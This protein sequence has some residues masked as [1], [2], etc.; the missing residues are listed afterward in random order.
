MR[1]I[2]YFNLL[3]V[4][5]LSLSLKSM[6][7]DKATEGVI[8]IKCSTKKDKN[9]VEEIFS[10]NLVL[11]NHDKIIL[12]TISNSDSIIRVTPSSGT[13]KD[14]TINSFG[15]SY[16]IVMRNE[17]IV[18]GEIKE[19]SVSWS[20]LSDKSRLTIE[21]LEKKI[22]LSNDL[23]EKKLIAVR[24]KKGMYKISHIE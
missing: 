9:L 6:A 1:H 2:S 21:W 23:I 3:M 13:L 12:I 24:L 22:I 10:R 15:V 7:Q 19:N 18:V 4:L 14:I 8:R 20:S 17:K 11:S 5:T 16:S